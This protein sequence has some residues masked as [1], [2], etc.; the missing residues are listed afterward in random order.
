MLFNVPGAKS[1]LGFPGTVTLPGLLS[2]LFDDRRFARRSVVDHE[3]RNMS[4]N[5]VCCYPVSANE[6]RVARV[7]RSEPRNAESNEFYE[8]NR[9]EQIEQAIDRAYQAQISGLYEALATGLL[10]AQGDSEKKAKA[11]KKFK[12]GLAFATEVRDTARKAAGM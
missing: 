5:P 1:S 11:T 3:S 6:K 8:V 4:G 9:M 10:A 12:K 2:C 7:E